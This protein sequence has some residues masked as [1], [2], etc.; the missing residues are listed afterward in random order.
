MNSYLAKLAALTKPSSVS[1]V[2]DS[3]SL[4]LKTAASPEPPKF[5]KKS[6]DPQLTKLPKPLN[7]GPANPKSTPDRAVDSGRSVRDNPALPTANSRAP[8]IP[9]GI[10]AKIAAIE[11]EA[12]AKGWP[13]E[14]LWN[15]VFWGSPRGLAAVLEPE[16][17]IAEVTADYITILTHQ[18]DIQRFPRRVA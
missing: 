15:N 10:R 11:A 9:D 6:P 17:V 1:F 5:F 4:F 12:R 16:D 3:P 7:A 18:R 2:S 8:L 13:A 14:L